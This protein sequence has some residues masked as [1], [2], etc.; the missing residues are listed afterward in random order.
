MTV[1]AMLLSPDGSPWLLGSYGRGLRSI[2]VD[3]YHWDFD[4]ALNRHVK[5]G[6]VGSVFSNFV[7]VEP[8]I[9]KANRDLIRLVL[10]R[11]PDVLVFAGAS[12]VRAGA[13]AQIKMSRPNTKIVMVWPDTLL[14][15]SNAMISCLPVCDL[16]ASYSSTAV[17]LLRRLGAPRVEWLPF[18]ADTELFP[19]SVTLTEADRSKFGC[20]VSF[21]GN[22]RPERERAITALA[23]AGLSV[24]VWGSPG[25]VKGAA[26]PER[27]RSVFGGEVLIGTSLVKAV[28]C[29]RISLN[30]IDDTNYPAANM[31]FFELYACGGTP[32]SSAC[33]EMVDEYP[34]GECAVYFEPRELVMK[35]REMLASRELCDRVAER[36]RAVTL[37][38]HTYA[39]RGRAIL[40]AFGLG[41]AG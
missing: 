13:L 31:R 36:G 26:N 12:P 8:W 16:V 40:R 9:T 35:A 6:R 38:S 27:M 1:T 34:D 19:E 24:K 41:S 28:R 4:A 2:G 20:D 23:D 22:H 21:V 11:S 5:L 32:L 18:A 10:E 3:V 29:S 33:P 7:P 30:V 37:A 15:L 14:N 25:W 39:E 17:E